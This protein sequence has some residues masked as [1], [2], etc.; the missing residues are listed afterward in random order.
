M[1]RILSISCDKSL[2]LTR[3]IILERSGHQ[4]QSAQGLSQAIP[5][6][7]GDKF[8]LVIIGHT[9]PRQDK[10]RMIGEVRAVCTTPV[11]TLHLPNEGPDDGADYSLSYES[12]GE[13]V[14]LVNQI[15][16]R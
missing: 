13:F 9:V 1:A 4:V 14:R 10:L 11:L 7:R 2:L 6:C 12:P 5:F 8:D 15:L 16:T 3:Q